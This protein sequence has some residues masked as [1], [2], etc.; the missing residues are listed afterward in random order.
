M[1]APDPLNDQVPIPFSS[2]TVS[3]VSAPQLEGRLF[4]TVVRR[5][6]LTK[7]VSSIVV[8]AGVLPPLTITVFSASPYITN[9]TCGLLSDSSTVCSCKSYRVPTFVKA[10]ALT[11]AASW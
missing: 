7:R 5:T 9:P 6:R 10:G 2:K 4:F 3:T 1:G 8:L 11:R